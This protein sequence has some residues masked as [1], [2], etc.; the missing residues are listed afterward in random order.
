[1]NL[2]GHLGV[3]L[4]LLRHQRQCLLSKPPWQHNHPIHVA[5][6]IITGVDGDVEPVVGDF[7]W[8]VDC[9]DLEERPRGRGANIARKYLYSV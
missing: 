2:D 6:Q 7:D 9:D 8:L 1:L 3:R 4:D 5:N